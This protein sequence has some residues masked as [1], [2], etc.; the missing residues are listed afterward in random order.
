MRYNWLVL[1][2]VKLIECKIFT[3][4]IL[5][6]A[7]VEDTVATAAGYSRKLRKNFA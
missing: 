7:I 3:T 4:A 2:D 5:I 6:A 1:V